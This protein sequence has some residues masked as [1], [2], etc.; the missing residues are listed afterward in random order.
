MS[1]ALN[2]S[3]VFGR[4]ASF[5]VPIKYNKGDGYY[6]REGRQSARGQ[7]THEKC[8][9]DKSNVERDRSKYIIT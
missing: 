6:S 8:G 3:I 4:M 1:I 2:L 7:G 5:T 9:E